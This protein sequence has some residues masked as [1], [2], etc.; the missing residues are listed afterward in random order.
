MHDGNLVPEVAG[1]GVDLLVADGPAHGEVRG[2][3]Q[4]VGLI[5]TGRYFVGKASCVEG[6]TG[7]GILPVFLSEVD[8]DGEGVLKCF[9]GFTRKNLV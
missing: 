5:H 3:D 8:V 4:E 1:D 6:S 7:E 2:L 9:L